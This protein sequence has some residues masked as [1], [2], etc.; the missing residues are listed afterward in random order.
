MEKI[1]EKTNISG[2]IVWFF[3]IGALS[4]VSSRTVALA[5]AIPVVLTYMMVRFKTAGG[6]SGV[7]ALGTAAVFSPAIAFGFAAAF[8]PVSAAAATMIRQKRRFRDSVLN[9]SAAALAGVV[10]LIGVVWL[11]T[12]MLPVDYLVHRISVGLGAL[13]DNE[14]NLA[15]QIARYWDIQTGAITQEAV[16]AASRAGA[17]HTM[18][19]ILRESINYVLV[20]VIMI[21]SMLSGLVCCLIPRYLAKRRGLPVAPIPAFRD[22]ELPR[23]FWAAFLV[24][25]LAAAVGHSLNWPSFELFSDT[26]FYV[27]AFLF[28]VQA[29][30]FAD[31]LYKSG[32]M[33]PRMRVALHTL[34][35]VVFGGLMMWVGIFENIIQLRHRSQE[36][37]DADI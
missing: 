19:D 1:K 4:A 12:R 3:A 33:N 7:A 28:V 11:H 22:Y 17:V 9:A 23:G 36:K 37:G 6:I 14:V 16:L 24:S 30:S 5:P 29:V 25:Y 20:T 10:L 13:G 27:Y 26:V 34:S 35:V 15:Y 2:L 32:G 8:V 31:F 21:Y 18:L